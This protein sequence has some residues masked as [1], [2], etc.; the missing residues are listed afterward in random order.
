MRQPCIVAG[1]RP[2]CAS[3][4]KTIQHK[5][6]IECIYISQKEELNNKVIEQINPRYIFFPH[7]SWL[8]PASLWQSYEC[9]IFHMTDLPYG[10]GGSPLQNLIVRGHSET[11]ISALRCEAELDAG[12]I[13][14]KRPLSLLGS[15]EEIF[16]RACACIAEMIEEILLSRPEPVPQVGTPTYFHRRRSQD[17]DVSDAKDLAE[18]FDRIRMVDADGY[19][20]AFIDVKN[21]RLSFSRASLRT[22]SVLADVTIKLK[23]DE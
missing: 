18:L 23:D 19:P 8:I 4:A 3:I 9:V 6:G 5:L 15:A 7:W 14:M 21:F 20:P 11:K 16:I 12:P 22:N 1:S 10:R 2:W 13:Y 17:S